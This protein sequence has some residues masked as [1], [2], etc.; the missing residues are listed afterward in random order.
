[1][2]VAEFELPAVLLMA[3]V[4]ARDPIE[5]AL[6]AACQAEIGAVNCQYERVVEDASIKPVRHDQ[7]EAVGTPAR[8]GAFGPFVD[9]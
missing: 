4:L 8:V 6:E 2:E 3:G 9:P 5:P 1:M 7:V